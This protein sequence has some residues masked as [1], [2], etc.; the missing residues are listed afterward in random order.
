V[1]D[2]SNVISSTLSSPI[3]HLIAAPQAI[4]ALNTHTPILTC[5][6]TVT[7]ASLC[8]MPL[9]GSHAYAMHVNHLD[10]NQL[11]VVGQLTWNTIYVSTLRRVADATT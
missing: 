7:L 4:F 6:D 2:Q 10:A 1:I 8:S 11:F 5:L 3:S 9:D